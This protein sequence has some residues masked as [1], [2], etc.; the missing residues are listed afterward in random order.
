MLPGVV[1]NLG[2]LAEFNAAAEVV[3]EVEA[4]TAASAADFESV[5]AEST[6]PLQLDEVDPELGICWFE[7]PEQVAVFL[8]FTFFTFVILQGSSRV[9]APLEVEETP[10]QLPSPLVRLLLLERRSLDFAFLLHVAVIDVVVFEVDGVTLAVGCEGEGA[11]L[12]QVLPLTFSEAPAVSAAVASAV[13][14]AVAAASLFICCLAAFLAV[15]FNLD[16]L[17]NSF[18]VLFWVV[19]APQV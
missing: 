17:T 9:V 6:L 5:L 1:A 3:E 15:L 8:A 12:E 13:A 7:D 11:E 18:S 19:W 2:S 10:L 16:L 4:V 14:S